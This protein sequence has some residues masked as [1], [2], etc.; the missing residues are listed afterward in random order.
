MQAAERN[1][2]VYMNGAVNIEGLIGPNMIVSLAGL[3]GTEDL[4]VPLG[5]A[6]FEG[7]AAR[8]LPEVTVS[9]GSPRAAGN[10]TVRWTA[11]GAIGRMKLLTPVPMIRLFVT[12]M[13][14]VVTIA[15]F[16]VAS[17]MGPTGGM[18]THSPPRPRSRRLCA[19]SNG[20]DGGLRCAGANL[21]TATK[22]IVEARISTTAGLCPGCAPQHGCICL[23]W[24]TKLT[25]HAAA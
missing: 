20:A 16:T 14:P 12:S 17:P 25:V 2:I 23:T 22:S 24:L 6:T 8:M 21:A 18:G 10:D 9:G 11:H 13:T 5:P 7:Q 1:Y 3:T 15:P 19:D 4:L